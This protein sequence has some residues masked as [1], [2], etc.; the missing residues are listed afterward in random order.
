M[1]FADALYRPAA[2]TLLCAALAGC[3]SL[4]AALTGRSDTPAAA[5]SATAA[6]SAPQAAVARS[7]A[8]RP[9]SPAAQRA[10]DDARRALRA[11][12][13]DDA[14]RG[15][16]ALAQSNPEL[17]GAHAN[18]G[19]IYRQAGKLPEA[20]TE[21]ETAV[22]VSPQQPV[23]FNQLGITYRQSGQFAK[24]REAYEAAIALDP[25]YAAPILNL[26]I[27]NDLYLSDGAKALSLYDRYLALAPGG[28]AVV[29]KWV[30]ELKNR[31][32]AAAGAVARKEKQ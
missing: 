16:R 28:D 24:A 29:A 17:G 25:A 1:R 13:T 2:L 9:V 4:P 12:R 26:G 32:P 19:V 3:G 7:E 30:V 31:K 14:E 21:L 5:A 22:R 18:L 23:F 11:G 15:F 8:E 10:F 27:L 6:A 20:V